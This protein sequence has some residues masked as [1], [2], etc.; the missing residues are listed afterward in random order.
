MKI[1]VGSGDC[2]R[3]L[4]APVAYR[5]CRHTDPAAGGGQGEPTN[6]PLLSEDCL[7]LE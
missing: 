5:I 1:K 4:R 6:V 2:S 3:F 7:P